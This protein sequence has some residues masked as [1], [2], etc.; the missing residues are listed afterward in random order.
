MRDKGFCRTPLF[1]PGLL[2]EC[3]M[4]LWAFSFSL[5]IA[6]YPFIPGPAFSPV[7][8]LSL[9]FGSPFYI[10][11]LS[12]GSLLAVLSPETMPH[13]KSRKLTGKLDRRGPLVPSPASQCREETHS[14]PLSTFRCC[15]WMLAMMSQS[16]D[17]LK[18]KLQSGTVAWTYNLNFWE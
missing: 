11:I 10:H 14:L 18:E 12:P 2:H 5:V 7:P 3:V 4:L 17:K 15:K 16:W 9:C 8:I 6:G 1:L 13:V